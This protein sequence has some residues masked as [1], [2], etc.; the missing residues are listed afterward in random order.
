[1]VI[2]RMTDEICR[3]KIFGV[4]NKSQ[5]RKKRTQQQHTNKIKTAKKA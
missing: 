3:A 5:H 2:K 4:I 1:M